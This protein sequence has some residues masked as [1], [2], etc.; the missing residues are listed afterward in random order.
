MLISLV[1][2]PTT[3]ADR[4][5]LE[6]LTEMVFLSRRMQ[7]SVHS[8]SK[9][10]STG[11]DRLAAESQAAD[12]EAADGAC[13]PPPPRIYNNLSPLISIRKILHLN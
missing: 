11:K 2:F 3:L 1:R 12:A 9:H 10:A 13:R 4:Q 6:F 7:D 8:E 5:K